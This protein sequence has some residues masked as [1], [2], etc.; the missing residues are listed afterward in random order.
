M[1][2]IRR[3]HNKWRKETVE[4]EFHGVV[5]SLTTHVEAIEYR[6]TRGFSSLRMMKQKTGLLPMSFIMTKN[7]FLIKPYNEIIRR[8]KDA[9]ITDFLINWRKRKSEKIDDLGPQVLS[10]AHLDVCFLVCMI[11][12]VLAF[13]AFI[14][15]HL[16][17]CLQ[18]K[19]SKS[20]K[21]EKTAV[22][23]TKFPKIIQVQP[24]VQRRFSV[25]LAH[26]MKSPIRIQIQRRFSV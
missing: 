15:E 9:G 7:H 19:L 25:C 24:R 20:F 10:F 13:A 4:Y 6:Y 18:K 17:H 16:W 23:V 5:D 8:L 21:K 26:E 2:K 14:F 1:G 3:I 22:P 11:P 12:L